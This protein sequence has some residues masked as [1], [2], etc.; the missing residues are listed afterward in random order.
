MSTGNGR[1]E[2]AKTVHPSNTYL[3]RVAVERFDEFTNT[4]IPWTGTN[5]LVDFATD[6][7]GTVVIPAL[8]DVPLLEIGNAAPG[9]YAE[10]IPGT[11]MDAL[12]PYVG[13]TI[14][15]IAKI[16]TGGTDARVVT[17]L[18]VRYPRYAQ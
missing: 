16:G 9:V 14:Y 11:T 18:V 5:V 8:A 13:T 15:Q 7:A 17:P 12:I 4:F 6:A 2:A 10:T 1:P 3:A